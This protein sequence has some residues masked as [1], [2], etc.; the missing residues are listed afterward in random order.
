[1]SHDD[2]TEA[3]E[4]DRRLDEQEAVEDPTAPPTLWWENDPVLAERFR[5]R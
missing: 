5:H 4:I 2:A 1:M 3:A